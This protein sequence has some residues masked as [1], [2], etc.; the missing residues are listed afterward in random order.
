MQVRGFLSLGRRFCVLGSWRPTRW[1]RMEEMRL[2]SVPWVEPEVPEDGA[3]LVAGAVSGVVEANAPGT[4][5]YF[6]KCRHVRCTGGNARTPTESGLPLS[7]TV[8]G[9]TH[10]SMV[11]FQVRELCSAS[12]EADGR[13]DD[14]EDELLHGYCLCGRQQRSSRVHSPTIVS[15]PHVSRSPAEKL[16]VSINL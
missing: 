13:C 2:G 10:A 11:D 3:R 8:L 14:F 9:S 6:A 1:Q 7:A 4:G 12:R 15:G 16:T 5:T